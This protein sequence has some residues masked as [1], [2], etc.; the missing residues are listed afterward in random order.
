MSPETPQEIVAHDLSGS[1]RAES[2]AFAPVI[3][4]AQTAVQAEAGLPHADVQVQAPQAVQAPIDRR[5]GSLA[6]AAIKAPRAQ[7]LIAHPGMPVG[8]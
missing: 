3:P 7:D 1:V 8:C 6:M 4:D 2:S 5:S